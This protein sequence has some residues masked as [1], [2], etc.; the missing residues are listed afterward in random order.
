M[1]KASGV[2]CH[3]TSLPSS[4]GV[5]DFGLISYDFINKLSNSGQSYWQILPIGN[6][7]E[8]GCPYATDSAFGC[9]EYYLSPEMLAQ[10]LKFDIQLFEHLKI[11]SKKVD[12][13]SVHNTF[14]LP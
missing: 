1:K 10:D 2:L 5:G 12:F 11:E 9:A 14:I 4:Y 3:I 8:T 7:D 13:K 6:T